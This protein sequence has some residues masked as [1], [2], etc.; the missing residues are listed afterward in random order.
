MTVVYRYSILGHVAFY[1]L[2]NLVDSAIVHVDCTVLS[3]D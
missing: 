3:R 2:N 1:E